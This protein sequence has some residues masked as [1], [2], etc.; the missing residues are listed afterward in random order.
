MY[1]LRNEE[2]GLADIETEGPR[3]VIKRSEAVLAR[4]TMTTAKAV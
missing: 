4:R 3:P 1:E 2:L